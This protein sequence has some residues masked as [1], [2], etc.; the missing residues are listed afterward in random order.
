MQAKQI[1]FRPT[2]FPHNMRG[3]DHRNLD[4]S[5]RISFRVPNPG[6]CYFS[7]STSTTA[8]KE[9]LESSGC[10]FRMQNMTEFCPHVRKCPAWPP[11]DRNHRPRCFPMSIGGLRIH[12]LIGSQ[13][14]QVVA[15]KIKSRRL[16][17]RRRN[18]WRFQIA[19]CQ[20]F[21]D[22]ISDKTVC[23]EIHSTFPE[24]ASTEPTV[25]LI[26]YLLRTN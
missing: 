21:R 14:D 9:C 1:C 12:S 6:P 5:P 2:F 17:L 20:S 11:S 3:T 8:G 10:C 22:Y 16:R 23:C 24:I 4:R 25:L 19:R 13:Q 15:G 26:Y 18:R 7:F